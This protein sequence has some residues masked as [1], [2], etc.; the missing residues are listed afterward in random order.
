MITDIVR[1][2]HHRFVRSFSNIAT[3]SK[4]ATDNRLCLFIDILKWRTLLQH[5]M[6]YFALRT[7]PT[8]H[9]KSTSCN[10]W[11]Q[12]T[13]YNAVNR[14]AAGTTSSRWRFFKH[15]FF[16]W[17]VTFSLKKAYFLV[18]SSDRRCHWTLPLCKRQTAGLLLPQLGT[19]LFGMKLQ[20]TNRTI[21]DF[22]KTV[23]H[24]TQHEWLNISRLIDLK[25]H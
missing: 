17:T 8:I 25:Y 13:T 23:S 21:C 20:N 24:A 7:T 16:Q 4:S 9:L 1:P 12:L 22:S 15:I 11:S 18:R 5:I 14:L 19:L 6:T 2:L 10:N 3:E